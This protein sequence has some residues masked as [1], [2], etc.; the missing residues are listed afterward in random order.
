MEKYN[1]NQDVPNGISR[2][3]FLKRAGLA[4]EGTA[5]A[6]LIFPS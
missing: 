4:I 1:K 5:L 3:E 2:R 6:A